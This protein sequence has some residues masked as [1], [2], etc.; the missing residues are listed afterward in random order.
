MK[1]IDKERLDCDVD[2][3]LIMWCKGV[4]GPFDAPEDAIEFDYYGTPVWAVPH[5]EQI[6]LIRANVARGRQIVV[7]SGNGALWAG[8]VLTK[9]G[10]DDLDLFVFNKPIGY[11]DDKDCVTWMGNRIYIPYK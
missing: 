6:M 2:E 7:H 11:I 1:V 3:T 9:L 5:T 4:I 10:L 8:E